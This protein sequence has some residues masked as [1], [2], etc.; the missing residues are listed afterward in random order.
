MDWEQRQ[1]EEFKT[2]KEGTTLAKSK[3]ASHFIDILRK[4][5]AKKVLDLGCNDGGFTARL[6]KEGFEAVGMDLPDVVKHAMD[7]YPDMPFVAGSGEKKLPFKDATFDAVVAS[8]VI[9]HIQQDKQFV[10]E[11]KR[12]LKKG[13]L[14]ILATPNPG[15]AIHA[16]LRM[17][18]YKW[19]E[20]QDM[21]AR[22]YTLDELRALLSPFSNVTITGIPFSY[23]DHKSKVGWIERF[24]ADRQRHTLVAVA[25][26]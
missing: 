8:E 1:Q 7:T 2:R 20:G 3:K 9:E 5:Q 26:R 18:G 16:W 13:G 10:Q 17:I 23:I 11:C 25:L 22:E 14:L 19:D 12:I 21:H 15:Y 6:E 24:L 4:H